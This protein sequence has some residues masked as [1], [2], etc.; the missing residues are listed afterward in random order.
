MHAVPHT[1]PRR[2]EVIAALTVSPPST[3]RVSVADPAADALPAAAL[4]SRRSP[5]E[6]MQ[7]PASRRPPSQVPCPKDKLR[8][9]RHPF[10]MLWLL[11]PLPEKE[12]VGAQLPPSGPA[13]S[14]GAAIR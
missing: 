9:L 14:D 4:C 7:E 10:G 1:M 8:R 5:R 12:G 13:G 3:A 2:D 6:N 11:V